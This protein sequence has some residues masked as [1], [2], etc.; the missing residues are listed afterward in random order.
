MVFDA[1]KSVVFAALGAQETVRKF[2]EDLVKRGE[3]SE[4][5]GVH[6]VKEWS[7]KVTKTGSDIS[8][9]ISETFTK[10]LEKMNLPTKDDIDKLNRK[11]NALSARVTELEQK[12]QIPDKPE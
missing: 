4:S 11:V 6:L 8:T 12:G 7:E 1:L 2:A 5:Q 3:L 9:N 10:T